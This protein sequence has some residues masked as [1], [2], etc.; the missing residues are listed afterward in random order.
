M[1]GVKNQLIKP[2]NNKKKSA[3]SALANKYMSIM[4]TEPILNVK[5]QIIQL[6]SCKLHCFSKESFKMIVFH[7]NKKSIQYTNHF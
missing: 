3:K 7:K 4:L 5:I 2:I 1:S 6:K